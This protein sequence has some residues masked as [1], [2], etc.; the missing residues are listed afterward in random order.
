MAKTAL[1]NLDAAIMKILTDYETT[2]NED[3]DIVTRKVA[4]AG[5]K[6]IGASARAMFGGSGKYAAGWTSQT[7]KRRLGAYAVIYNQA[8]PGLAHLLENGHAKVGGGRVEGRPH[9]AP[10]E[11][12]IIKDYEEAV[13]NAISGH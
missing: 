3:L 2:L 8:A 4:Q 5:A 7:E 13:R 10:V 12:E 6:A 11:Q 1:D 9:I